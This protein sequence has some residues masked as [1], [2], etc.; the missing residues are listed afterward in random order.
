M[1]QAGLAL[2]SHKLPR[3]NVL[4]VEI[5][6]RNCR[7]S[8]GTIYRTNDIDVKLSSDSA[9]CDINNVILNANSPPPHS[10]QIQ[11]GQ[12]KRMSRA[13]RSMFPIH[14]LG[15]AVPRNQ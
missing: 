3:L 15:S 12:M 13:C 4:F 7:T 2:A 14:G 11:Y 8:E 10:L 6:E 9:A 1:G 5:E